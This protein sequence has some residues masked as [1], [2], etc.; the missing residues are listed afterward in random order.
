[1]F[2]IRSFYFDDPEWEY[3]QQE[4][5]PPRS[6]YSERRGAST[7]GRSRFRGRGALRS[8]GHRDRGQEITHGQK[9]Q[10]YWQR[11]ELISLSKLSSC[12]IIAT[13][14]NEEKA[15]LNAM[16]HNKFLEN[17]FMLRTLITI[18][19]K[20][21]TS[22]TEERRAASLLI[23]RVMTDCKLFV[24]SLRRFIIDMVLV[25]NPIF[26]FR[27]IVRIATF[28]IQCIPSSTKAIFPHSDLQSTGHR[29]RLD[30]DAVLHREFTRYCELYRDDKHT[31]L[32]L[33]NG[34]PQQKHC[35]INDYCEPLNSWATHRSAKR[36]TS[37]NFRDCCILPQSYEI[38]NNDYEPDLR[39]NLISEDYDDPEHY[40]DVQFRLLREDFIGPLRDGIYS[41]REP[42]PDLTLYHGVR[43][44]WPV[45]LRSGVGFQIQFDTN[46]SGLQHVRW[47]HSRKLIYG[48]LL[49]FSKDGFKHNIFFATVASP[50][51]DVDDLKNGHLI[52]K[53]EGQESQDIAFEV[54][55]NTEF[56]MVESSA[57]FEAYRHVLNGLKEIVHDQ[58]PFCQYIVGGYR[59]GQPIP[60][61]TFLKRNSMFNLSDTLGIRRFQNIDVTNISSWPKASHTDLNKAQLKAVYMALSREASIIQGPPGTGKTFIGLKIVQAILQNRSVWDPQSNSPILVVCYTN[62]ALD[63][64][65]S[66]IVK[67]KLGRDY[68]PKVVR[69]G[70]RCKSEELKPYVLTNIVSKMKEEGRVPK[71]VFVEYKKSL[72]ELGEYQKLFEQ[73]SL[74]EGNL[75]PEHE[76]RD[77][78]NYT[79]FEQLRRDGIEIWLQL[80][81]SEDQAS[82]DDLDEGKFG[83][84]SFSNVGHVAMPSDDEMI[85][86][87]DEPLLLEEDRR[88]DDEEEFIRES[89]RRKKKKAVKLLSPPESEWEVVECIKKKRRLK[90]IKMGLKEKPFKEQ[91]VYRITNLWKLALKERWRLYNYWLNKHI[92]NLKGALHSIAEEYNRAAQECLENSQEVNLAAISNVHVIGM[93]TTGAAKH[94]YILKNLR[95]RIL[96]VEEAAEVMEAHIITSLSSSVQQLI[97]IGDHKQLQPKPAYYNLEVNYDFNISLFERLIEKGFPCVTLTTQHRMRPEIARIVGN[98][99]YGELHDSE[100]VKKYEQIK[101]VE[102]SLFFIDHRHKENSH[103]AGGHSHSNTFEAQF[104]ASLTQYF[105]KQGYKPQQITIITMYRGQLLEIKRNMPKSVFNGVQVAA[106]DDF[107]GEENDIIILS[108]VRSNSRNSIGFLKVENRVCVALSRARKGMFVIGDFSMLR[109]KYKTKWPAIISEMEQKRYLGDGLRLCCYNHPQEKVVVRIP[110]DFSKF[111][112]GGC[113]RKCPGKLKCGHL[114]P[115]TC[116]PDDPNH[117]KYYKCLQ[118]CNKVLKCEH[119]CT[120]QCYKCKKYC[121]PCKFKDIKDHPWCKHVVIVACSDDLLQHKCTESCE[122]VISECEHRC[123]NMCF[124]QCVS[125]NKCAQPCQTVL[126]CSHKCQGTCGACYQGR[127]HVRCE[128]KC[129]KTLICGHICTSPCPKHCPPCSKP[130]YNYC[131]HSKCRKKCYEPCVP[132][133]EKPCKWKCKHYA[134]TAA[135]GEICNRPRCDKPCLRERECGHLCIGLCGEKCPSLCRICD[136]EKVTENIFGTETK[137]DAR[138]I[139]LEDCGHVLEV[140]GLDRLMQRHDVGDKAIQFQKCPKPGC[141]TLIRCSLRYGN[142]IKGTIYAM[143]KIK[144]VQMIN[145]KDIALPRNIQSIVGG[146]DR[147]FDQFCYFVAESMRAFEPTRFNTLQNQ[148]N[149]IPKLFHLMLCINDLPTG[150]VM[151]FGTQQIHKSVLLEKAHRIIVFMKMPVLTSQQIKEAATQFEMV[152]NVGRLCELKAKLSKEKKYFDVSDGTKFNDL[153]RR[154]S[155]VQSVAR[156]LLR[157]TTDRQIESWK[158]KY[159]IEEITGNERF[160]VILRENKIGRWFMC[161]QEHVYCIG[162]CDSIVS[163]QKC[164]ECHI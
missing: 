147:V 17:N 161:L 57:Y 1:M 66:G 96:I 88:E 100:S 32:K 21:V 128:E 63:Q 9:R 38:N 54:D 30:S 116:H 126:D 141:G 44:L 150:N 75:V 7:R 163:T 130:C 26:C 77:V 74:N 60:I 145:S 146:H 133:C 48:S 8:T 154:L 50:S 156:S 13:V 149:F 117:E 35:V 105:L 98:H 129:G 33:T 53:F 76:L 113:R 71:S 99:I 5:P 139:Q 25:E 97:L 115:S 112:A 151:S 152:L 80:Q 122:K 79:H 159:K 162:D 82:F 119:L 12:D 123:T 56:V 55:P 81:N 67:M 49:C 14:Q 83:I 64:F 124:E 164:P 24:S 43:V 27:Q 104:V 135:C 70:G 36:F 114:C 39:P 111:P 153:V 138:F 68:R 47:D 59:I 134:C 137:D 102:K 34:H 108:L 87:V 29:L 20:M 84:D 132:C 18:L 131:C 3:Q 22:P 109:G 45:S 160:R 120:Q 62:H 155:K 125:A 110:A 143:N 86:I 4:D 65:L 11:C 158:I 90:V 136:K 15:F 121:A 101:G 91:D 37:T 127:L 31:E 144:Q 2:S 85:E 148:L 103:V 94:S 140:S 106:V 58:M 10:Q 46:A 142:I 95:P 107:Q 78:I 72:S 40:L 16:R 73:T 61:P 92:S 42:K 6:R 69:V 52:V 19:H 157:H 118:K 28:C 93:T 89:N 23:S 41:L 51:R